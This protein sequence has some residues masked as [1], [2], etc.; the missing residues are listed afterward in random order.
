[1]I[2]G[3]ADA[4]IAGE[5]YTLTCQV[6]GED[7]A[8]ITYRWFRNGSLLAGQTSATFSFS[9]L[10]E[11]ESRLYTC[12]GT[13]NSIVNTSEGVAISVDGKFQMY[14]YE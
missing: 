3:N 13:K 11:T 4:Q 12:E 5:N 1:M 8:A 7:A 6:T 9:P 10:R 14:V 2:L